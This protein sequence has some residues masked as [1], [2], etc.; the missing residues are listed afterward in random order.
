MLSAPGEWCPDPR[1]KPKATV[2]RIIP[3][4]GSAVPDLDEQPN[5]Q[6]FRPARD[7]NYT[8]TGNNRECAT[9]RWD[10]LRTLSYDRKSKDSS[11]IGAVRLCGLESVGKDAQ[12]N[13][14]E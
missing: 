4:N 3:E 2:G 11:L 8:Y 9:G 7:V 12:H 5:Q 14:R 6:N 10:N 13:S 1:K